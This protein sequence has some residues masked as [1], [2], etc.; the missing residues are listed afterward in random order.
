VLGFAGVRDPSYI[1][2]IL[3]AM[4][5][6]VGCGGNSMSVSGNQGDPVP[7]ERPWESLGQIQLNSGKLLIEDAAFSPSL[8]DGL[9]VELAPGTYDVERKLVVYGNDARNAGLR[10]FPRGQTTSRGAQIGET[11]TDT[12]EL[13]VSDFDRARSTLE[14]LGDDAFYDQYS[15]I[16]DQADPGTGSGIVRH[17][18][19]PLLFFV[20]SGFGD[21]TYPVYELVSQDTR[22][23]VEIEFIEP[24]TPYPFTPERVREHN[25]RVLELFRNH[26]RPPGADATPTGR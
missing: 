4:L 21:G 14:A 1:V 22:S 18:N 6:T 9:I 3:L 17:E 19:A 5:A 20:S 15:K 25:Q 11:W 23:G 7:E 2:I 10:V 16:L 24:G 13:G 8:E 12:G 26:G